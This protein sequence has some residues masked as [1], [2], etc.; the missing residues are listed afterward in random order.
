MYSTN[1]SSLNTFHFFSFQMRI[2]T[3][4]YRKNGYSK[5]MAGKSDSKRELKEN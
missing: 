4:A 2:R 1:H 5:V 3:M